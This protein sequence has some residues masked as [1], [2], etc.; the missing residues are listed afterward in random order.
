MIELIVFILLNVI[1]SYFCSFLIVRID[2]LRRKIGIFAIFLTVF[3]F[4]FA[5]FVVYL[6]KIYF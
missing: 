3:L 1:V 4:I 5:L 6:W 2:F